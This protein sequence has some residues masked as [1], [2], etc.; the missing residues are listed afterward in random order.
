MAAEVKRRGLDRARH[1]ACVCDGQ[2]YNWTLFE[3]HRLPWGCIGI[4]DF[5]PLL[6]YL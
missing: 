1:K 4:L 5:V 6:A 3:L 2:H